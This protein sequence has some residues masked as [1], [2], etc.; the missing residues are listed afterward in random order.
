M[1]VTK[2]KYA[3][4]EDVLAKSNGHCWYC[5]KTITI[6]SRFQ[7]VTSDTYAIDHF[8]P[9][10]KGGSDDFSN[11]V[12]SCWTCN[13]IKKDHDIQGFKEALSRCEN[14]IPLFNEKQKGYLKK[15]NIQLPEIPTRNLYFETR[16]LKP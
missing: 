10:S 12:P 5:G 3:L 9:S 1:K 7:K 15:H 2:V 14:N 6:D 13:V 16:G 11:L 4:L 8:V